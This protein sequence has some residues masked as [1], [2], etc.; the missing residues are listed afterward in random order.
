V[1]FTGNGKSV[2]MHRRL[3][4]EGEVMD[5]TERYARLATHLN[6]KKAGPLVCP[7]CNA[8]ESFEAKGTL[9]GPPSD[10]PAEPRF[11]YAACTN[12]GYS[13]FFDAETSNLLE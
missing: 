1:V 11:N 12:C 6:S 8:T 4:V 13:I 3:F 2:R 5:D 10:L 9:S 7:I